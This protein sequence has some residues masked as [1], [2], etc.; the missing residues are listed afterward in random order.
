VVRTPAAAHFRV[1]V[2]GGGPAGIGVAAGLARAGVAPVLVIE[3]GHEPGG[4]PARYAAKPGGVPTFVAWARG[5]VLVGRRYAERL[6]RELGA[7]GAEVW[8][9]A[10]V[11]EVVRAERALVVVR[12]GLG[13]QRVSAD[14][15]VL[16]CGS[17]EQSIAERG[18]IAGQ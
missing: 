1:V 6:G 3:R 4:V 10:Q 9:D 17:R 18:W 13:A 2:V 12:P 11:I 8:L 15:V 7:S 16:A 14:A 5:R